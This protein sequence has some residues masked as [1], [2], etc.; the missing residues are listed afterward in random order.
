MDFLKNINKEFIL[1]SDFNFIKKNYHYIFKKGDDINLGTVKVKTSDLNTSQAE[2]YIT[3]I[4]NIDDVVTQVAEAMVTS[5]TRDASKYKKIAKKVIKAWNESPEK[6]KQQKDRYSKDTYKR[7]NLLNN[8]EYMQSVFTFFDKVSY[9]SDFRFSTGC[10]G[11][12]YYA[13]EVYEEGLES[14]DKWIEK[15]TKE[16]ASAKIKKRLKNYIMKNTVTIPI[17]RLED[18][19]A[20]S[21][22]EIKVSNSSKKSKSPNK[23]EFP[24]KFTAIQMN[25]FLSEYGEAYL[26]EEMIEEFNSQNDV[27]ISPLLHWEIL[28]EHEGYHHNDGQVCD[29]TATFI[30]P[31]GHE[32]YV[33]SEHCLMTGWNLWKDEEAQPA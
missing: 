10:G 23:P 3:E 14:I 33:Y 32:Y 4:E 20:L 31:D 18:S 21:V 24:V 15:A 6:F 12:T 19:I 7:L 1:T 22:D 29:Y 9:H 8:K 17:G 26:D 28:V 5:L 13:K 30:H 2:F 11:D 27:D 16:L 25:Y